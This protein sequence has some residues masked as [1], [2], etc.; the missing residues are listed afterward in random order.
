[1]AAYSG[2]VETA[3]DLLDC[4]ADIDFPDQFGWTALM[5]AAYNDQINVVT[6]LVERG[7]NAKL[8]SNRGKTAMELCEEANALDV[9]AFF[10]NFS[11]KKTVKKEKRA[12]REESMDSLDLKEKKEK[13][14]KKKKEDKDDESKEEKKE[15]KKKEKEKKVEEAKEESRAEEEETK[16]ETKEEREEIQ[17]VR[18]EEMKKEEVKKEDSRPKSSVNDWT[19]DD[20]GS[21]LINLGSEFAP[22]VAVF[23]ENNITGKRLLRLNDEKLKALGINSLGLRDDILTEIE[24]LKQK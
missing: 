24:D 9:M 6:L 1:L 15:K 16:E 11:K 19:E 17:E 2:C 14:E 22:Y 5:L 20:V 12:E 7:A 10:H 21:W 23:K 8:V 3:E 4:G 18:R 13:K